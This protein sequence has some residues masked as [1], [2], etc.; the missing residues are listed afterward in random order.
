MV[1][2]LSNGVLELGRIRIDAIAQVALAKFAPDE[3]DRI[4][5]GR[6]RGQVDEG[7]IV[8]YL[9]SAAVVPAGAIEDQDGMDIGRQLRAE[10]AQLPIH[11]FGIG[12]RHQPGVALAGVRAEGAEQIDELVLGLSRRARPASR[13]GPD[14]AVAALL[15]KARF[16]LEPQL[17][18]LLR[19]FRLKGLQRFGQ[20]IF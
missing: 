10:T 13:V 20:L 5:F 2:G 18:A 17:K 16:I 19:V 1:P 8:G 12:H 11:R 7:E 4:E 14:A 6:G 9:K 3:F 15:T